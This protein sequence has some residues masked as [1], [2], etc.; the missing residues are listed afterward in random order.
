MQDLQQLKTILF[1]LNADGRTLASAKEISQELL[2]QD[3]ANSR[4]GSVEIYSQ[5]AFRINGKL[6]VRTRCVSCL[7]MSIISLCNLKRGRT[8]GCRVCNQPVQVI[9][10][11]YQRMQGA[12]Q[13]CNNPAY[14]EW[15]NYGARGIKFNF[16]CA[17]TATLWVQNNLG[18]FREKQIDRID[19]D[20]H[21]EAG[22]LRWSTSSQNMSHTRR[23]RLL[24]AVHLFRTNYPE[25]NYADRTLRRMIGLGL[26]DQ[27][28]IEQWMTPSCK[29]K[30]VYGTFSKPDPF[31]VSQ[32]Q[33][34]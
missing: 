4:Y 6:F 18:V 9:K 23:R 5:E 13:R 26:S 30:G 15:K 8:A 34:F 27:E 3:L 12:E 7:R 20:G 10:W 33:G 11:L 19:N 21:Y 28:I 24:A 31:I 25:V 14:P 16:D 32:Y 17:L 1:S 22:N 2:Q 29:P